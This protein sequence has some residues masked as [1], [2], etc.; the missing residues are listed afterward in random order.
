M[1]CFYVLQNKF[2]W[3]HTHEILCVE[4]LIY[5]QNNISVLSRIN[6]KQR[7][8]V[9]NL[10]LETK[11]NILARGFLKNSL[12]I[13]NFGRCAATTHQNLFVN[14]SINLKKN[15]YVRFAIYIHTQL[16]ISN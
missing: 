15:S 16:Y 4:A 13:K 7:Q 9:T 3:R 14:P 1:I 8:K 11:N 6:K 10:S 5:L 2:W 12:Q